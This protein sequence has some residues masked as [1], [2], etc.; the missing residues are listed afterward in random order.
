MFQFIQKEAKEKY[1]NYLI[2]KYKCKPKRVRKTR[3]R[4]YKEYYESAFDTDV[5]RYK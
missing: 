4:I 2:G 1:Y 5:I 3:E